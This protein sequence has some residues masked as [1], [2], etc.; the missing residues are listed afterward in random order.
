MNRVL[1]FSEQFLSEFEFELKGR[2]FEHILR[3]LKLGLGGTF[4][5]AGINRSV[6]QAEIT[7]IQSQSLRARIVSESPA[8]AASPWKLAMALSRPKTLSRKIKTVVELGVT[9]IFFIG[10]ANVDKNYWK[11]EFLSMDHLVK[12]IVLAMEQT[13]RS[14]FPKIHFIPSFDNFLN[15]E[16]DI[17]FN[18]LPVYLAVPGPKYSWP[19]IDSSALAIVGPERG[20]LVEEQER[21]IERGAQVRH[22]GSQ[23]LSIEVALTQTLSLASVHH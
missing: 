16:W 7:H 4:Q 14:L 8:P 5:F 1:V 2:A 23:A 15:Y 11:S 12:P 18:D 10:G 17:Y 20:F 19:R 21:L 3:Q 6:G 22:L 13:G 9:E